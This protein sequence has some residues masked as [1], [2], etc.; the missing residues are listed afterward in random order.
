MPEI[1]ESRRKELGLSQQEVADKIPITRQ[2]Y[3]EIENDKRVPSVKLAKG[4][5]DVLGVD[6]TI[7]F[8]ESVN[9]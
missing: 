8:G 5:S 7:F 3:N 9:K 6:W 2:Y 4:I 1:I